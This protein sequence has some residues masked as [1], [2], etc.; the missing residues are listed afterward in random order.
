M[1]KIFIKS[2][3]L[4]IL[5]LIP[6][7]LW[8]Q[9][10]WEKSFA[11]IE[12]IVVQASSSDVVFE[13]GNS[14][15]VILSVESNQGNPDYSYKVTGK[16]LR[17]EEKGR[18]WGKQGWVKFSFKVPDGLNAQITSGSGNITING[19]KIS[20]KSNNGSGDIK[21]KNGGG[22]IN[23]NVGSGN[24]E[25]ENALGSLRLN[26]GSGNILLNNTAGKISANVGSGNIRASQI[27]IEQP[28]IFNSGSGNVNIGLG[29]SPSANLS[30]NSG[31]GNASINLNGHALKGELEMRA[32][33]KNGKIVAPFTF[34]L[35]TEEKTNYNTV[36]KKTKTFS[37][38]DIIISIATG[39][40]T[41]KVSK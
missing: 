38:Q 10:S 6:A 39:S 18:N 40:G 22:T 17:L 32:S 3:Q 37:D 35:E 8:A 26:C 1:K 20:L 13:K 11:N 4:F 30:A 14:S 16:R 19:V 31:S 21:I 34:D 23:T 25:I 33:K 2:I 7:G 27:R 5:L 12:E 28:C 41:A 15:D 29:A 9:S 36:L 24:I